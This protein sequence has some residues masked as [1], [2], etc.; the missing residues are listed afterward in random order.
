VA[1]E[2]QICP[3][4]TGAKAAC[5]GC[6]WEASA[7]KN[8]VAGTPATTRH[9]RVDHDKKI[10][11]RG[12]SSRLAEERGA[13]PLQALW[14]PVLCQIHGGGCLHLEPASHAMSGP[15]I[16]RLE[17][18][19]RTRLYNW[20]LDA[21]TPCLY[22]VYLLSIAAVVW[23]GRASRSR[24]IIV[25]RSSAPAPPSERSAKYNMKLGLCSNYPL[26][27]AG[28]THLYLGQYGFH[29]PKNRKDRTKAPLG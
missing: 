15:A 3:A 10:K 16:E 28:R 22:P 29:W 9:A 1:W 21:S 17:D 24:P 2:R 27:N 20:G 8:R 7:G 26:S 4:K 5:W 11:E 12:Y 14:K 13:S 18:E 25:L 19:Q 6:C 23:C